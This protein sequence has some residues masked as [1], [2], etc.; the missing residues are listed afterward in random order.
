MGLWSD[1]KKFAFKGNM[2]DLAIGVVV[3]SAFSGV[4]NS[5]VKDLILP[6][7]GALLGK[8]NFDELVLV[9]VPATETAEAVTLNWGTFLGTVLNF[10]IIAVSIFFMVTLVTKADRK[11]RAK[12]LAAEA[13]KKKK[14]EEEAKK[15][16]TV[17]GL[18]TEIRDLLQ[19][20]KNAPKG[21]V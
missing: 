17:E 9:L 21:T 8:I 12:Q 19:E 13:E 3:G 11:L 15:K 2:I 1:F 16:P 6:P 5:I 20:N 14:E 4:V 18:L 7:I 10:L